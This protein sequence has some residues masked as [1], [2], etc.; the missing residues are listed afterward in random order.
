MVSDAFKLVHSLAFFRYNRH[1]LKERDSS[2]LFLQ[3]QTEIIKYSFILLPI[4]SLELL[5]V[6]SLI[7]I[8]GY[9]RVALK[10]VIQSEI[11]IP[12]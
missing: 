6:F 12:N 5:P 9:I 11:V 2:D 8:F 1:F 3:Y 7:T 4:S 10:L